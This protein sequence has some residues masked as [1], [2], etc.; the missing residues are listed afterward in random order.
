MNRLIALWTGLLVVATT[1]LFADE[2]PYIWLEEV[3]GKKALEWVEERNRE[4]LSVLEALPAFQPM[5][6]RHMEIYN[7]DER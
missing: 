1:P 3:T 5:F 4:S 7:S 2:D 6:D